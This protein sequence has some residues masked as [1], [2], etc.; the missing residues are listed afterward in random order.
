MIGE[1]EKAG[2]LETWK[3]TG[4]EGPDLSCC[5]KL[6]LFS[7]D[8]VEPLQVFALFISVQIYDCLSAEMN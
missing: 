1:R 8:N 2:V 6:R 5:L 4:S 7:V 3:C